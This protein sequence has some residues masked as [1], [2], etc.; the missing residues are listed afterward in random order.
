MGIVNQ[1]RTWVDVTLTMTADGN[2]AGELLADVQTMGV[3]HNMGAGAGTNVVNLMTMIVR[4]EDD[5]ATPVDLDFI[6]FRIGTSIGT[7]SAAL[8]MTDALSRDIVNIVRV[9]AESFLDL[10]ANKVAVL[11]NI[12]AMMQTSVDGVVFVA[13][14]VRDTSITPSASGIRVSFGFTS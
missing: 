6:F 9:E 14:V 3:V 7:E 1:A 11:N 12:N 10:G 13:A 4:D 8:N 5:Q 2:A